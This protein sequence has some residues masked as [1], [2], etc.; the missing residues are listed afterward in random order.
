[1]HQNRK[2]RVAAALDRAPTIQ[3][4]GMTAKMP[5]VAAIRG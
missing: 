5:A 4:N 3:H 2:E 1:M